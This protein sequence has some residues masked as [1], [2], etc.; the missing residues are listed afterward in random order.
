MLKTADEDV[1][2]GKTTKIRKQAMDLLSRREYSRLELKEKIERRFDCSVSIE[3]VLEA[4]IDENLQSDARYTESFVK[5]R[6]R[7]GQGFFRILR[8]IQKKGIDCALLEVTCSKLNIDWSSLAI[9]VARRKV[10]GRLPNKASDQAKLSR[11]LQY[12]GFDSDQTKQAVT[13]VTDRS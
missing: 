5:G 2:I 10:G 7:R 12:R 4:L 8:D 3:R 1:L 11:F 6:V 13:S 9:E